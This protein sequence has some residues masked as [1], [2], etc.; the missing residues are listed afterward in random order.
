MSK[1]EKQ[2]TENVQRCYAVVTG[3]EDMG[4][5]LTVLIDT[6]AVT[7]AEHIDTKADRDMLMGACIKRLQQYK[8]ELGKWTQK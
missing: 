7:I 2:H 4:E 6:I 8:K 1:Q 3:C 5:V